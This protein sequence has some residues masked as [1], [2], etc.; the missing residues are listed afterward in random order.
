MVVAP[1]VPLKRYPPTALI[2]L[3]TLSVPVRLVLPLRLIPT[4]PDCITV[5]LVL[6]VLPTVTVLA[7][8]PVPILTAPV[9]PESKLAVLL[10]VLLTLTV[11]PPVIP[12][13]AVLPTVGVVTPFK[14]LDWLT[15]RLPFTVVVTPV[16]EIVMLV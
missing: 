4:L 5:L 12:S 11:V 13:P 8:L 14:V 3:L 1:G 16:R 2:V 6:V 7:L 10:P 15:V 9:V